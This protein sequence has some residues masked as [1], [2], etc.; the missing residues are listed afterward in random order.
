MKDHGD[1][2]VFERFELD[3]SAVLFDCRL[4]VFIQ[5]CDDT[6]FQFVSDRGA[7]DRSICHLVSGSRKDRVSRFQVAFD[8]LPKDRHEFKPLDSFALGDRHEVAH[9]KHTGYSGKFKQPARERAV[10]CL[11][12]IGVFDMTFQQEKL[13][14]DEFHRRRVRGR[15]GVNGPDFLRRYHDN[16]KVRTLTGGGK[17]RQAGAFCI[18]I[19]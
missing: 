11:C 7:S 10:G 6:V 14:G 15:F 12:R 5:C 9:D 1:F 8:K 13:A 16:A 3:C 19:A 18:F 4:N 17:F 2:S